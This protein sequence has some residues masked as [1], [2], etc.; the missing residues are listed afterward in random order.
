[1]NK[2]I[3][4]ILLAAAA[5]TASAD[6]NVYIYRNDR[7]FHHLRSKDK[8][9]FLH[10]VD[11]DG[12]VY[13]EFPGM[14]RVDVA[15][16][17]SCTMREV[18]IPVLKF[19]FTD[20]PDATMLWDKEL[21]LNTELDIEGNGMVEDQTGLTLKVKGRG[22]TTWGWPKKP[23]RLKFD[24]KTSICGFKKAKNYVLLANFLDNS[25]IRTSVAMWLANKLNVPCANHTMPCHIYVNDS[26]TGVYTMTEKVGINGSSVDIDENTGILLEL[27]LEYDE[28]YKFKSQNYSLPVMVKDPDFDELAES[29]G[30]SA[31]DRLKMWQD[32]FNAAETLAAQGKGEQAFDIDSYVNY[33]LLYEITGNN[34][35]GF[36]KSVYIHKASPGEG[37]KWIFGP[38]WDF[39][40]AFNIIHQN[41]DGSFSEALPTHG[42]YFN[43]LT[44]ALFITPAFKQRYLERFKEFL[45]T[46][47]P[48]YLKYFDEQA[49]LMEPAARENGVR[50]P[51]TEFLGFSYAITSY[52]A[53]ENTARMR[54]WI[55]QRVEY[56][57]TKYGVE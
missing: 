56:M 33:M 9:E 22:N 14:E 43:N 28:P 1:M 50:W 5:L 10:S 52:D 46:I 13:A 51:D 44:R 31:A 7:N 24:K 12:T 54:D 36:P 30:M 18:D 16:I 25:L 20:Y 23:M 57:K 29:G 15:K 32:D 2:I 38:A 41:S 47:Y 48:E 3:T 55:V 40:V 4:T 26:Y 11:Q 42:V 35:M 19:R 49:A 53:K 27:S 37:S 39:D 17:D 8:I 21:Y 45:T 6:N 34:E